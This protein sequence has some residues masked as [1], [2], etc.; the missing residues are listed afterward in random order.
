MINDE[1]K[2]E[3]ETEETKK[4]EYD[5]EFGTEEGVGEAN[6]I[7]FKSLGQS[8]SQTIEENYNHK[9]VLSSQEK[10]LN[11]NRKRLRNVNS[12]DNL[13][14]LRK[15]T[16]PNPNTLEENDEGL[17]FS[18]KTCFKINKKSQKLTLKSLR[19]PSKPRPYFQQ[20]SLS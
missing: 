19:K 9:E 16:L 17:D 13:D 2:M 6:I 3:E 11:L 12:F 15:E 5:D 8:E 4:E 10:P 18:N 20:H 14:T 7:N 1:Q